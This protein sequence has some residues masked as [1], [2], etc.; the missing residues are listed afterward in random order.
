MREEVSVDMPGFGEGGPWAGGSGV[1]PPGPGFGPV[2]FGPG[3]SHP[4]WVGIV[5]GL[6][7]ALVFGGLLTLIVLL[8]LRIRDGAWG[9]LAPAPVALDVAVGE[10]RMRYAR[11]ELARDDYLRIVG[12]LSSSDPVPAAPPASATSPPAGSD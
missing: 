3:P 5:W 11:G 10:A 2:G 1:G 6:L 12:D 8:F 7:P 9:R 4:V